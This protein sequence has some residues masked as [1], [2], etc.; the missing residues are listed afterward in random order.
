MA[1]CPLTHRVPSMAASGDTSKG[2][3]PCLEPFLALDRIAHQAR[4]DGALVLPGK[5]LIEGFSDFVGDAKVHGGHCPSFV[6]V[7]NKV[8]VTGNGASTS[9]GYAPTPSEQ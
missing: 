3:A 8:S 1:D 2:L 4:Y 5:G 7:F 9:L 6:E